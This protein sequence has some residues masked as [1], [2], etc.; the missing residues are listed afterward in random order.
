MT[1]F[2]RIKRWASRRPQTYVAGCSIAQLQALFSQPLVRDSRAKA[3]Q[4]EFVSLEPAGV[5]AYYLSLMTSEEEIQPL[6]ALIEPGL[7]LLSEKRSHGLVVKRFADASAIRG[8]VVSL[9]TQAFN[10]TTVQLVSNDAHLLNA[11]QCAGFVVPPPWVAFED[12]P[13]SWWSANMQGAQGYYNDNYFLAYFTRLSDAQR[14]AYYLRYH[15]TAEW[16]ASL[17]LMLDE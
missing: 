13:P 15:A 17:A 5:Q 1:I 10:S 4:S 9:S 16:I 11:V 3:N 12:Y 7:T 8:L 6:H 14:Q 2:N